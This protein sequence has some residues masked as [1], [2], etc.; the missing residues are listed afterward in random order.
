MARTVAHFFPDLFDWLGEVRDDR[1]QGRVTY[2]RRFLLWMG[3][4]G[5]LLKLGSRRRLR[6]ELD[7]PQALANLNTLS[8]GQQQALAHSDTLNYFLGR[9][10]ASSLPALRRKM[11][12]RLLRMKALDHGRLMG[13]FLLVLD[14]TG[15]L[16]F[17]RRH[18]PH[19][20]EQAHGQ[21]TI[22][23]HPVPEA[24]LVA[25]EGLALSLESEFIENADPNAAR[26]DC[27]HRVVRFW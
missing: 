12:R 20:L 27:E 6:F 5:F 18:C 17:P 22:Y 19:C 8:R 4:M 15:Q 2:G 13:H 24:K 23:Y 21:R 3:L 9:V 14:G 16:H 1:D 25:P 7:S 10:P 11:V 26:Q